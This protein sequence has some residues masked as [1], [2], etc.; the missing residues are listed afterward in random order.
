MRQNLNSRLRTVYFLLIGFL[1]FSCGRSVTATPMPTPT[2]SPTPIP[3]P[4]AGSG[5]QY[6]GAAINSG[7][8]PG[9]LYGNTSQGR[10]PFKQ[11]F[12]SMQEDNNT[13][14]AMMEPSQGSWNWTAVTNYNYAKANGMPFVWNSA[15]CSN[16]GQPGWLS[17]LTPAQQEA[18]WEDFLA[19][20]AQQMPN[21]DYVEVG[22]EPISSG[23]PPFASALGGNGSTGYDWYIQAFKVVKKYFPNAKIGSNMFGC[24][25]PGSF[26][27]NQY[28]A[29]TQTLFQAG[30]LDYVSL[31]GYFGNYGPGPYP[32]YPTTAQITA[33]LQGYEAVA[34]GVPVHYSEWTIVD[35]NEGPNGGDPGQLAIAQQILPALLADPNVTMI[36]LWNPDCSSVA[37]GWP[38]FCAWD[39]QIRPA[40]QYLINTVPLPKP[41]TPRPVQSI[42]FSASPSSTPTSTPTPHADHRRY[43]HRGKPN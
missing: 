24:E 31:E 38:W 25:I 11:Y 34:P 22:N 18:A 33:G 17:G 14:W 15:G 4:V 7:T 41:L 9:N 20:V 10:I 37:A 36:N 12:N 43:H 21:I 26:F 29:L 35:V 30:V 3:T 8:E 28:I 2:P 5:L 32:Y 39:S 1:L 16:Q 42:S 40:F 23:P 19:H 27:Y 6:F 13:V